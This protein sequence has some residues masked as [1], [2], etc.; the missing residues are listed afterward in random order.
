MSEPG[1]T[2][3]DA[4]PDW[5]EERVLTILDGP[6]DA[7]EADLAQLIAAHPEHAIGIRAWQR[8]V[9]TTFERFGSLQV[10][11]RLGRGGMGVVYRAH[12]PGLGRD[13]AVKILPPELLAEPGR[14]ARFLREARIAAGLRHENIV[15][16]H[17]VGEQDGV[18]FLAMDL[19]DGAGLD[20]VLATLRAAG[21]NAAACTGED[22]AHAIAPDA[23]VLPAIGRSHAEVV[24]R[25]AAALA[26]ALAHAHA[27]EVVHRDLKP[28][29][30]MVRRDGTPMLLDFG[31]A[32][33]TSGTRLTR[34]GQLLGTPEY[35]APEQLAHDGGEPDP[36]TDVWAFG[37]TLY[38]MLTFELP[39]G[40]FGPQ[41]IGR[42]QGAEPPS[43][44]K[45]GAQ[46]PR[47]LETICL[48]CLEKDPARRYQSGA[49]LLADLRAFL[50]FR[51][52]RARPIGVLGRAWRW[53]KRNRLAAAGVAFIALAS[54]GTPSGIA[55]VQAAARRDIE[56]EKNAKDAANA[57]LVAANGKLAAE[58]KDKEAALQEARRRTAEASMQLAQ[59]LLQRGQWKAALDAFEQAEQNG[60]TDAFAIGIGRFT[61]LEGLSEIDDAREI[62]VELDAR[63]LALRERASLDLLT[64][65]RL[66]NRVADPREGLDRVERALASGA[67]A[68][69]DACYA[70]GLL[71]ANLVDARREFEAA[72]AI[73]PAHRFATLQLFPILVT[74]GTVQ[75]LDALAGRVRALYPDDLY[76]P[77]VSA[78]V[79]LA[80]G[81][82]VR[83]DRAC[84]TLDDLGAG[85][86]A[87][88]FR[89]VA[90]LRESLI[91]HERESPLVADGG[92][93][94][95]VLLRMAAV[96]QKAGS[97]MAVHPKL[98]EVVRSAIPIGTAMFARRLP[99]EAALARIDAIWP[100][101]LWDLLRSHQEG[102][103]LATRTSALR[104]ATE[105][106]SILG[107]M[108]SEHQWNWCIATGWCALAV[109][110]R[111][112][113]TRAGQTASGPEFDED[114][115]L[116]ADAANRAGLD[117][118]TLLG[119]TQT[120]L[121]LNQPDLAVELALRRLR[122]V[123]ASQRDESRF[124][125]IR[126]LLARGAYLWAQP[127]L[128]EMNARLDFQPLREA[129]QLCEAELKKLGVTLP[130][131][132]AGR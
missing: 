126:A 117:S 105:R 56:T 61:A 76:A 46:V 98:A 45:V 115:L 49:E 24:A 64:G 73:D 32:R 94:L 48:T 103:D 28:A 68:P 93:V 52:V 38:E 113:A 12:D 79:G 119:L 47:D 75:D 66:V 34:V 97:S 23:A 53:G 15:A 88:L 99:S 111:E 129:Q 14:V 102:A 9:K 69:A 81:D 16:I 106:G 11:G 96:L 33:A 89:R 100:D 31:L 109:D 128:V 92:E 104:R 122:I 118:F 131:P 3:E 71:A 70:R 51:P 114:L 20:R 27:S 54:V 84:D 43:L 29:N 108:I 35:F 50:E 39:F 125:M 112:A 65:E 91:R 40:G 74:V 58:T 8:S 101:G 78:M 124:W 95:D 107:R 25:L 130:L 67:L 121:A 5:I 41:L 87:D 86:A 62:L 63:P 55:V 59:R 22:W 110:R 85:A 6:S 26:E 37:V 30:V 90:R 123:D 77:S 18:P 120:A 72:L 116:L 7:V 80:Q 44:R 60:S 17:Q 1:S 2:L 13:V 21:K 132:A 83:V 36:R 4:L 10:V 19:V 82:Q 57:E 127:M 42:I